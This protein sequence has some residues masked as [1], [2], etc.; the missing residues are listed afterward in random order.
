[1]KRPAA[2]RIYRGLPVNFRHGF[3]LAAVL[4]LPPDVLCTVPVFRE[5]ARAIAMRNETVAQFAKAVCLS[6]R[7]V[8][9]ALAGD[10][11]EATAEVLRRVLG[12]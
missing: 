11:T 6:E 3:R 2:Y 8:A 9:R 10:Y 4:G 7:T 5:L 1:M 12:G